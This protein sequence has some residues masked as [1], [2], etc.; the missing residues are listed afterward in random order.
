MFEE[1]RLVGGGGGGAR[2]ISQCHQTGGHIHPCQGTR[3]ETHDP[4]CLRGKVGGV[5]GWRTR[6]QHPSCI[7][8]VDRDTFVKGGGGG[9]AQ[10]LHT[11]VSSNW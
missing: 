10:D 5:G 6:L 2:P 9:E 1:E 8:L 11:D 7:K 4:K 3:G